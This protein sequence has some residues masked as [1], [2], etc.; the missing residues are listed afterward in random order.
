LFEEKVMHSMASDQVDPVLEM[1]RG[2]ALHV[3]LVVVA[4][5]G[6][7][8]WGSPIL[9]AVRHAQLTPLLWVYGAVYLS[10][11]ALAALPRGGFRLRAVAFLVLGY[12]NAVVSFARLGLMGSG[13]LYLLAL[14]VFATVL[15]GSQTGIL[16][17]GFSLAIYGSFLVLIRLGWPALPLP[18]VVPP[19]ALDYWLE[20]GIALA[21]FSTCVA[22]LLHRFCALQ[23]CTLQAERQ[24]SAALEQVNARLEEYSHTLEDRVAQRTADLARANDRFV[25]ELT[26]AAK[27]QASFLPNELP[28]VPG[29]QLTAKLVPAT[30]MS[31]DFYDVYPLPNGRLALLVAD[32]VDK[33]VGA[34]LC[35]VMTWA[36][37]RTYA[38]QHPERPDL[39][40]SAVNRR[41]LTDSQS[42]QFVTL[43]Y[44]VL[45]P[46][47][48]K[49]RYCNAGHHPPLLF[50]PDVTGEALR[51][52]RT[53]LPLGVSE[54]APWESNEVSLVKDDV[55]VLYTDGVTDALSDSGASFGQERLN[56]C[57]KASLGR[58]VG[59]IRAAL[60]GDVQAFAGDAPQT[61]DIAVMVL[62]RGPLPGR[63]GSGKIRPAHSLE[64]VP[65]PDTGGAPLRVG[66]LSEAKV[67]PLTDAH[68]S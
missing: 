9:N 68:G 3:I 31:G 32:V 24:A 33:G 45:E 49:L 16:T 37:M 22:I 41:L 13:R 50:K 56:A 47:S 12:A 2:K 25:Q 15:M 46:T 35:M 19:M 65:S 38:M 62:A 23:R 14:P 20:A 18:T 5:A 4:L 60:L 53:G 55:L 59:E 1:W 17:T 58:S 52:N 7:P 34:A 44:G 51:L 57:V 30:E 42:N 66:P 54:E 27:I 28:H 48:G 67:R 63:P 29:W 8:A 6:L 43:F 64:R 26:L 21:V 40:L 39:V 36:L 11:V 10:M 61:D